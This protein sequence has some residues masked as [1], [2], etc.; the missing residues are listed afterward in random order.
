MAEEK[1]LLKVG[2][3]NLMFNDI[4][5]TNI[6]DLDIYMSKGLPA[7]MIKRKHFKCLKY[8]DNISEIITNPDYIGINPNEQDTSIELVKKYADNVM[9]GIKI[10]TN[11]NYL[12]ISTMHDIQESKIE[13]RLHSGRLKKITIDSS[14]EK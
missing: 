7:H 9:I 11:D 5:K 13:R 3:Y 14:Q 6:Q 2:K 8:L 1:E 12:Y 4:L 10:D